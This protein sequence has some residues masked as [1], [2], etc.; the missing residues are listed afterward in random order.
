L[1]AQTIGSKIRELRLSKNLKQSELG[2][3]L[4]VASSTI[5]NWENGRRLPSINELKRVAAF[6]NTNLNAFQSDLDINQ[7]QNENADKIIFNQSIDSRPAS[8]QITKIEHYV[9]LSGT[10]LLFLVTITRFMFQYIF[11]IIGILFLLWIQLMYLS[12]RRKMLLNNY[13]RIVIPAF[14]KVYYVHK[15]DIELV[16]KQQNVINLFVIISLVSSIF[17][18]GIAI[19]TLLQYEQPLINVLSSTYALAAIVIHFF[20]Y[21]NIQS[22]RLTRPM[23]PYYGTMADLRYP[24]IY[25]TFFMDSVAIVSF[26]VTMLVVVKNHQIF[27]ILL[28]ILFTITLLTSYRVLVLL[29][30]FILNLE[31]RFGESE[32][33][34]ENLII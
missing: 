14:Y 4:S 26:A 7:K 28:G 19:S 18:Y 12:K 21:Q 11:L 5:S 31:L 8:I 6:F 10:M 33:K 24:I 22:K 23:I 25:W 13:K 1:K 34:L 9:L 27:I 32:E 3:A 30:R 29:N 16:V 17:T 20:C 2:D 15:G